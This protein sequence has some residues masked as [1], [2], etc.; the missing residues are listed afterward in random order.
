M[1]TPALP[2]DH[3]AERAVLGS[4]LLDRDCIAVI[5]P[6]L[7]AEDFYFETHRR[8]YQAFVDCYN[9]RVPGD[10]IT[11]GALLRERQQLDEI[12][13]PTFLIDLTDAVPTSYHVEWYANIVLDAAYARMM[14]QIG[15]DI[16]AMAY[17]SQER[18]DLMEKSRR[19]LERVERRTQSSDIH[20][21]K[22]ISRDY[23]RSLDDEGPKAVATG[24]AVLDKHLV[25]G[26]HPGELV[27]LAA[28]TSIGKTAFALQVAR[29]VA[30]RGE[31]VLFL[32]LEMNRKALWQRLT[33]VESGLNLSRIREHQTLTPAEVA[34]LVAADGALSLMPLG[35]IDQD[36]TTLSRLRGAA[37]AS[38]TERGLPS[39]VVIDYL[40][41]ITP[42]SDRK[43]NTRTVD[44]SEISRA[45]KL[46]AGTLSC[47]VLALA[48]LSRNVENR[49]DGVPRLSDLRESGSL[50]QDADVVL[51]LDR[52]D[53]RKPAATPTGKADVIVAKHRQGPLGKI[54]LTFQPETGRFFDIEH[55]RTP[56]GYGGRE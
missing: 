1:N 20:W 23:L 47:P 4:C 22:E 49:P 8:I 50:E 21:A 19:M 17:E 16:A 18:A 30:R 13:G 15:G 24:L 37:L 9:R 25:G 31:T 34:R 39:L 43:S 12:G 45:C 29:N 32:S 28:R 40:N 51:F 2:V 41:L 11:I 52:E 35:I 46:L 48:Q 14:I 5:E 7:K 6:F 33:A 27:L 38:A 36:V 42:E 44:V 55:Y 56:A 54:T 26:F 3:M 53:I 10:Y